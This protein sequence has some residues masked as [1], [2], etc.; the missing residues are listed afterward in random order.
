MGVLRH[1]NAWLTIVTAAFD[2]HHRTVA[3]YARILLLGETSAYGDN[4]GENP[5]IPD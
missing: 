2:K 4:T 1:G 5:L 3:F